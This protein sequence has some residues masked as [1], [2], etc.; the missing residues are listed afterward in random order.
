MVEVHLIVGSIYILVSTFLAK[1]ALVCGVVAACY[2]QLKQ[3]TAT[4]NGKV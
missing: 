3:G 2:Q 4:P 1:L